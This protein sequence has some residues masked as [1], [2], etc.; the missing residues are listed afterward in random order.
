MAI[1]NDLIVRGATRCLNTLYANSLQVDSQTIS[2]NLTVN[3]YTYMGYSTSRSDTKLSVAGITNNQWYRSS[4]GVGWY[5]DSYG[6]GIYMTDSTYVKTYNNKAFYAY[7]GL[8]T[9]STQQYYLNVNGKLNAA[10]GVFSNNLNVGN[11]LVSR[12]ISATNLLRAAKYDLQ[13]IT[14]V[15][16]NGTL[17][18]APSIQFPTS[19]TTS[20]TTASTS[21]TIIDTN[22]TSDV[23]AGVVWR[24]SAKVKISG[25]ING[26]VTGTVDGTITSINTSS[27]T[28]VIGNLSGGNWSSVVAGTYTKDKI[29]NLNI[30]MYETYQNSTYYP[31]GILLTSYGSVSEHTDGTAKTFID[32][33]GG[34]ATKPV[35]RLGSMTGL[36]AING[37]TPSGWG[38]YTSNGYFSGLIVST[39]GKIGGWSLSTNSLTTGTWGSS[40]SA[41]LCT[42]STSQK[43]IGGSPASTSGWVFTAGAN[44]GVTS[45]GALYANSAHISGEITATSGTIG[46]ASITNGVLLIK[47]AN[48][49][50]KI[51]AS[52]IDASSITIGSLS[53]ADDYALKEDVPTT[54]AELT[55]SGSY[56][57]TSAASN[58]YATQTNLNNEINARKAVYGTSSTDAGTATKVVTCSNFALYTGASVTVTF[59]K[60]NTS[61][62]PYLNVNSTGA[63]PIKSYTGA[64][65]TEGEYKWAAGATI[66]FTYD[67]TNW[68]MQDGGA[69]QAKIDAAS[70]ASTASSQAEVATQQATNATNAKTAAESAKTA[71]ESAKTAAQS[72]KT[73]AET[74][75]GAAETAAGNAS[76]SATNAA[77]SATAAAEVM[78]GFTILWNYSA[79]DT[80][81]NGEGYLCAFDPAT[82]TK[83]DANGWVKWN[84]VKRTI[85]KQMINPNTVLP[86]NIPIYV[87]CRLSSA[88]ATTGTNYMVWYN[89]GWKYAVMPTPSAV[90]GSWTWA[91]NTDIILGKF[92]ETASEAAL[93][94]YEIYNPPYTS[95]Q[96]TT[97]VVTAQSAST[98]A[99]SAAQTA[100]TYIT[101]IDSNN[102][103]RIQPANYSTNKDSVQINSTAI[104]MYRNDVDVMSLGDSSFRMGTASG[105]HT[106]VNSDGLHVWIGS[107]STAANE[108]GLFGS[109]ARIGAPASSRFLLNADSL[110]AYN[111]SNVKYFEVSASGLSFGGNA[112]AKASDIPTTVAQLTDSSDYLTTAVASNTYA[113]QTATNNAAK[114]ATSYITYVDAT[115]G[116]KVHNASDTTNYLQ[117]NSSAISMYK[118]GT[119]IFNVDSN[120]YVTVGKEAASKRNVYITD[121]AVQIRN[122]TS[123]LA[124]YGSNIRLGEL[125]T[126]KKNIYIS[127]QIGLDIRNNT[128]SLANFS[129]T[130]RIGKSGETN[131]QIAPT[132]VT[133]TAPDGSVALEMLFE[134]HFTEGEL[135][136]YG[137]RITDE[138]NMS[139]ISITPSLNS[140]GEFTN[141]LDYLANMDS[142]SWQVTGAGFSLNSQGFGVH[143]GSDSVGMTTDGET[144][145]IDIN[146]QAP[147][148]YEDVVVTISYAA[149]T[150]GTRGTQ[151]NCGTTSK[152]GYKYM[153][154]SIL[155]H[156]NTSTFSVNLIRNDSTANLHLMA[157]RANGNAVTDA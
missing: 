112:V 26:V 118:G 60:T 12:N 133:M 124:E 110:Q 5:N 63:K 77:N 36:D 78:G 95:K 13:T 128:T 94:E 153:G 74:A 39:S 8:Y 58:T 27:E 67:G 4:G 21:I 113:T 84:G 127:P 34:S 55:D 43:A 80:S 86:Y 59:S 114:T 56:L 14:Q 142:F 24:P 50:G 53:G 66:T 48:I 11:S 79:F 141:K 85:T 69:L 149:G 103:I 132:N 97:N 65:L 83:S 96:I 136:E 104:T 72:A 52:H 64:N 3:G 134:K 46:G 151:V 117:L 121:D 156:I 145:T 29:E 150:I 115:D 47:D 137:V 15:G 92:V 116:I 87:V 19:N 105:K 30:M 99:A 107:E 139:T 20:V 28:M 155:S 2:G 131:I 135:Y 146:G 45:S 88:T 49:S 122:N 126:N 33:Y 61:S 152:T 109:T 119:K 108:V 7:N 101:N 82:G 41:M 144:V 130:V 70:S 100:T 10:D 35:V 106:T 71:A 125:G 23:M 120:G 90:G 62:A 18:V 51:S 140:D 25:T 44:F 81:D 57:T 148:F 32:I 40:G 6:G 147:I 54:V 154:A 123:V 68:R 31:V 102:G 73:A 98:S 42:G 75:Q 143:V 157:Y 1:L 17:Y 38:L 129:D 22:I 16:S 37:V 111:S 138:N 76:Q 91:D 93:T 89:S 9:G